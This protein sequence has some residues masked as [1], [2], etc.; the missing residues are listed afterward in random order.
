MRLW[1]Y[2][3]LEYLPRKHLLSQLRECTAIA[4]A[5]DSGKPINHVII[6]RIY[7]YGIDEFRIYCEL[8]RKEFI[9][10][11]WTISDKTL[12][13]LHLDNFDI[14]IDENTK[15]FENWHNK[16]YLTQCFYNLQEKYDCG[17]INEDEWEILYKNLSCY[18]SY[19]RVSAF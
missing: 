15:I 16:R 8:V 9:R 17:M 1:H 11:D 5:I 13:K 6:N 3:I 14:E 12:K 18:I 7:D 19:E 4:V 2:E 10:R